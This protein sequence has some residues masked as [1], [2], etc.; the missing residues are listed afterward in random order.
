MVDNR[1]LFLRI[2]SRFAK[3]C[4]CGGRRQGLIHKNDRDRWNLLAELFRE[5]PDLHGGAALRSVHTDRQADDKCLDF[6]QFHQTR[7]ASDGFTFALIDSLDWMGENAEIIRRGD[8]DPGI[9]M[10][11]AERRMRGVLWKRFQSSS[12]GRRSDSFLIASAW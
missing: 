7:D 10:V 6:A 9:S 8:T 12:F 5:R 4:G 2:F 11:D 1:F 3:L